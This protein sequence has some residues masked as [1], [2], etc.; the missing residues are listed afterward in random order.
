MQSYDKKNMD[1]KT[2]K[3][4]VQIHITVFERIIFARFNSF[5]DC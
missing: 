2:V 1:V 5:I 4:L 3:T